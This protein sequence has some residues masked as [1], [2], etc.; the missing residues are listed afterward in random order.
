MV[1]GWGTITVEEILAPVQGI[2]AAGKSQIPLRGLSTDSRQVDAGQVFWALRGDR[3]DGHDFVLQAL[4]RNAAAAV[5]ERRW[6]EGDPSRTGLLKTRY[7]DRPIVV[8]DDT[9]R[10]LGNFAHW[11]RHRFNVQVTAITGSVGKTTTKEMAASIVELGSP[12]LKN[13]G[14]WNNLVGLPLTLLELTSEHRQALLE[15]GMNR[16]GEIGRLT[17]IADPNVG[18]ITKI[19]AAHLEGVGS[20]E[21]VARAKVELL[22]HIS[23]KSPV[24]LNGDDPLLLQVASGFRRNWISFGM[25]G[26]NDVKAS[27]LEDLGAEGVSFDLEYRGLS[28]PIRL[29]LP[30]VH[31]V[32]N[33]LGAAA[34]AFCLDES[35]EHI[36]KGLARFRGVK[37]R[38]MVTRLPSEI[39]LV[40]DTYNSN[41]ASLQAALDSL[42]SLSHGTLPVIVGL[43]EMMELGP[44]APYAHEEAGRR[45]AEMG[46]DFLVAVGEH[47]SHVIQGARSAGMVGDRAQVVA[48]HQE[49]VEAVRERAVTPCILFL[50]GSRRME[51]DKVVEDLRSALS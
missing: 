7:P 48:S 34:V 46:A 41:P 18:L 15:M 19:G 44:E 5:V 27:N 14:N 25:G 37:G 31:N 22:E 39:V 10:A 29:H 12:T 43:G 21:G 26:D 11:W 30:G 3:Y 17:E 20:L 40:D 42:R 45:V 1:T 16:P 4:E 35:V 24:I 23:P 49:M 28:W 32:Y 51:L 47:A 9:L 36:T 38:F 33:A 6:W 50:K 13:R 2:S 8:V